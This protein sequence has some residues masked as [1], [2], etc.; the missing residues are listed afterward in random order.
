[1]NVEGSMTGCDYVTAMAMVWGSA[2]DPG[3]LRMGANPEGTEEVRMA[4]TTRPSV[5]VPDTAL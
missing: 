2:P 1:M 4:E 3:I 5:L